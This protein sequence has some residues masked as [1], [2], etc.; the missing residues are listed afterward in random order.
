MTA[1]ASTSTTAPAGHQP[2]DAASVPF[3]ARHIGPRP[4]DAEHML[5]TLGYDSLEALVDA[6]VPQDIRQQEPLDLPAPLT[7]AA[8]MEQLREIAG[9]N[10][11]KTQMIGQG[12]YDT[13]LLYTSPSPRD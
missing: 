2:R 5:Q 11:M 13:C 3:T 1:T 12:F 6:A 8:V 9:R 7:E 4:A 10:I